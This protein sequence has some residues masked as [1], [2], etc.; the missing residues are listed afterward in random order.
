MK[1]K[2]KPNKKALF[3]LIALAIGAAAQANSDVPFS[4]REVN[5][6]SPLEVVAS[7]G[8]GSCGGH[9]PEEHAQYLE[10]NPQEDHSQ[11]DHG[12]DEDEAINNDDPATLNECKQNCKDDFP[13]KA[14]KS[15][16]KSCINDCKEQF[17]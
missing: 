14:N 6:Y 15:E 3:A 4:L 10:S 8:E 5:S 2:K 16:R 17:N 7:C 1:Q 12:D 11:H 9:T 13:G